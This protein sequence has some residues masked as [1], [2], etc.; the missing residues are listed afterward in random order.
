MSLTFSKRFW[1]KR[2]FETWTASQRLF[3]RMM[4]VKCG[5]SRPLIR[6][7]AVLFEV[8][9][10]GSKLNSLGDHLDIEYTKS[11]QLEMECK[12]SRMVF[13]LR[14]WDV[15]LLE[16]LLH[17]VTQCWRTWKLSDFVCSCSNWFVLDKK[18]EKKRS[19]SDRSRV[20]KAR[21]F[22]LILTSQVNR[23]S[24]PVS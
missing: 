12:W 14:F 4:M 10:L 13:L 22:A 11:Q 2:L 17:I 21:G 16:Y 3:D 9:L 24:M 7:I 1:K 23:E 20:P 19:T 8:V 5:F 15:I 18:A 6:R